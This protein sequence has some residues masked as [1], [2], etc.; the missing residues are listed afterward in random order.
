MPSYTA[1]LA[2]LQFVLDEL[3][4]LQRYQDL[5]GFEELGPELIAA[6]LEEGGRF[7]QEV[8]APLNA[9]GDR[10]GCRWHDGTVTTPKGFK[11]AYR[12]YVEGGWNGL[13]GERRYGGQG[14]PY[15]LGTAFGEMSSAANMAFAMYPGLTGGAIDAISAGG[16]EEQKR[17]YLPPMIEGRWSGTMNLTEPHCGTDLGLLRTRAEPQADGSYRISGTKIFIS[18]GEH[19]LTENIIH[20]VLARIPGGPPGVKGISL[21]IVP[22]FLV[23]PDGSL[24]ERN[25]VRCGRIEE[26][27]GIHGNATCEMQYDGAVGYLIGEPH[28]GLK[29]M[30]VMMNAARLGVA[31]QGL[32]IATV[33][34]QNAV[35][36]A[37]ERL[38]GRALTGP[39]APE[40]AADP[41]IVHPDVRRMLL[42]GRAFTEGARA[43][44]CWVAL[45]ADLAHKH[46]D[47]QVCQDAEDLVA[48]LTPVVKAYFTDKGF[49]VANLALQ[50]YGGHGYIREWGM[51]QFV[52]DARIAQIYEGANGIQALDLVG[53]KLPADGGRAIQRFL[54]LVGGFCREQSENAELAPYVAPLAKALERLQKA[55]V[56]L[57]EQGPRNPD[58]AAAGSMDYLHLLALTALGWQ[59]AQIAAVARRR[60]AEGSGDG[61]FYR[62][63][64]IT[65][66][67]FM[68]RML[69]DTAA[70]LAKLS[71]GAQALMELPAEG[72]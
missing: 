68:E 48:L 31:V 33:A 4:Q 52:R 14:L 55:T 45:Q 23:N 12:A 62:N 39:K 9:A 13:T 21:F 17:L 15:V 27:M 66:R 19:D 70:H 44:A 16:S 26:K 6:I 34:Y 67:F 57:Q 36:Y 40:R 32:A 38:Q 43:L 63:K 7:C 28:K 1:P 58:H 53:R 64:L 29:V 8:L 71:A 2:D 22:K 3:L 69:P 41:I 42:V 65:A 35:V 25:R 30:F 56:W 10:E 47:A 5:P 54:A 49:E 37:R 24:A 61:G 11:E 72:F 20:L 59:W 18:A 60:L 51:E 46:P 50:C